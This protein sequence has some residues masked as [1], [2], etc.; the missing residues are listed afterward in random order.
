[1]LN[2]TFEYQ[3]GGS[4]PP[5]APSYVSRQADDELYEGLKAGEFCYVLNSR[6]MGKSSLRIRTME[7]LQAEGIACAVIDLTT[8]GSQEV[9]AEQWYGSL[10]SS[11]SNEFELT[12]RFNFNFKNWSSTREMLSPGQRFTEFIEE[13]LLTKITHNIVIFI[14]E[15]D[16]VINLKFKDNFFALIRSFYNK[17]AEK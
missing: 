5:D 7:K 6:Q 10:I 9:K 1:M 13:V 14:D 3:I 4:L 11:L 8:I 16:Q 12:T 15:I 17:R 2:A